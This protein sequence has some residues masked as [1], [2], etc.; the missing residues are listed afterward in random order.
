MGCCMKLLT[1]LEAGG[2]D[3]PDAEAET[4]APVSKMSPSQSRV[5]FIV[6]SSVSA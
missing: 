2:S 4:S 3:R 5:R 1:K 6:R